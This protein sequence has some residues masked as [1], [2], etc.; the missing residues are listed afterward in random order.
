MDKSPGETAVEEIKKALQEDLTPNTLLYLFT[1]IRILIDSQ[2]KSF[3]ILKD[4][5][6]LKTIRHFLTDK[7]RDVRVASIRTLRYVSVNEDCLVAIKNAKLLHFIIKSFEVEGKSQERIEACKFIKT[8][9]DTSAATFPMCFMTSLIALAETEN[10]DELKEFAIEAIRILS[11]SNTSLVAWCG[12]FRLLINSLFDTKLAETTID[13]TVLTLLFLLNIKE[14]RVHLKREKE[15][16]RILS[17]F[18]NTEQD[19]RQHE[20]DTVLDLGKKIIIMMSR[21]W[22]GLIFLASGGLRQVIE[23]ICLP[24][25]PKIKEA[26]LDIIEEMINIPVETSQ[27]SRSLLKNYLA[28]LLKALI[29]CNLYNCLTNLAIEKSDSMAQRARKLLKLVTTAASDLLPDAPQFSLMLDS[30]K[31]VI[32]AEIVS[33]IDSSTRLKGIFNNKSL[34]YTVCEY[35]SKEP[36]SYIESYNTVIIGI[37]KNYALNMIDDTHFGNLIHRSQVLK[38]TKKWNWELIL[39]IMAGPISTPQRFSQ[40]LK[41]RFLKCLLSYYMPSRGLFNVLAWHP[42]NFVKSQVG[43]L[44]IGLLLSQQEGLQLLTTTISEGFFV[45]RKSFIGEMVDGIEDEISVKEGKIVNNRLFSPEKTKGFLVR[46]YLKWIGLMSFYRSGIALLNSSNLDS[47]LIKLANVEHISS[48]IIPYLNYQEHI[49]KD[50]LSFAMQSGDIIIRKNAMEHLRLIFRAGISE[51]SWAINE[52]VNQLYSPDIRIVNC[53][54]SVVTELCQN[55]NNLRSFIETGPQT[56]TRLG[57][58]G[59]KCLISFLS[60]SSGIAYLSQLEFIQKEL[61]NWKKTGNLDYVKKIEQK[62]ELG[63]TSQK[64]IYALEIHTPFGN[65]YNDRVEPMWLRKLPFTILV[66]VS[67]TEK[68]YPVN[69]WVEITDDDVCV[70]SITDI[71]VSD[72]DVISTCLQLGIFNF[73]SKGQ[74]IPDGYWIKCAPQDRDTDSPEEYEKFGVIFK[75]LYS[76]KNTSL[77]GVNYRIQ[78]LPKAS[79]S[80]KFPKHLYGELV[81]TKLGLKKLQESGH[82]EELLENLNSECPAIQ[83]RVAL[84]G[85]GHIGSSERGVQYLSKLNAISMMVQIAERSSTL[86]LRGTAFQALCLLANT[87]LGRKELLKYGWVCSQSNIALP[88]QSDKIFWLETGNSFENFLEKSS[89]ADK[90]IESIPLSSEEKEVLDNIIGLGNFVRRG[91]SEMF[92]RTKRYQSPEIFE[93]LRLFHAVMTHLAAYSFKIS[94]RRIIHK[95]FE[96]V[97]KKQALIHELDDFNHI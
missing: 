70:C 53:A 91:E 26:I 33:E 93:S 81:Q 68:T 67:G 24:I 40:A 79:P 23:N 14:T 94:I 92:L 80:I 50:F 97:Y 34:M 45:M 57:D 16:A 63:L 38:E 52:I 96:K 11:I 55:S 21:S 51:L 54:I 31:S 27:K 47:M 1:R 37:Y 7:D 3:E 32:A 49:S 13:N 85:L 20:L 76:D 48:A 22:V 19:L 64:K 30:K 18:T 4:I 82:P 46:E 29:H 83:K 87:I 39:Q 15:L 73:D 36:F 8:W 84:W 88:L 35:L 75:F 56:L 9:L 12:G 89:E 28:M 59:P 6:L 2:S 71:P 44:L 95:L 77:V 25:N 60:S 62:S 5:K 43:T 65:S 61:E 58:E 42:N 74:E 90:I 86:S 72:K 41:S 17:M 66:Y 69:T 10:E 78:V